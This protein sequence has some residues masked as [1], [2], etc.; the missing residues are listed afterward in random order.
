MVP[1]DDPEG[2]GVILYAPGF[3]GVAL[4]RVEVRVV[5][6]DEEENWVG[7][8][9]G[10]RKPDLL[11]EEAYWVGVVRKPVPRLQVLFVVLLV[12]R[13]R[14]GGSDEEATLRLERF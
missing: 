2:S 8:W 6:E 10:A 1:L 14:C 12:L 13:R 11:D 7:V 9:S 3:R 4:R 5:E